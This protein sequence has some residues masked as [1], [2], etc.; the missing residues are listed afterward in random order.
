MAQ[1]RG[2]Y[3]MGG[4]QSFGAQ[5]REMSSDPSPLDTIREH[6]SK[7][8]DLLDTWSE[9]VKPYVQHPPPWEPQNV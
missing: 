7:I 3:Q 1:I 8:E 2:N 4:P 6:T 9:P 5:P